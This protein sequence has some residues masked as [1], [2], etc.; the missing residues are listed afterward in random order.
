MMKRK[1]F[2]LKTNGWD[3]GEKKQT[4]SQRFHVLIDLF[5][6]S[7]G[8]EC[9]GSCSL[10]FTDLEVARDGGP[11]CPE[12]SAEADE[13]DD[14]G[15]GDDVDLDEVGSDPEFD[16]G[17]SQPLSPDPV[18]ESQSKSPI[19]GPFSEE[20]CFME[21]DEMMPDSQP[22]FPE[23]PDSQPG[24]PSVA[25]SPSPPKGIEPDDCDKMIVIEDTPDKGSSGETPGSMN[26]VNLEIRKIQEALKHAK[27]M[28]MARSFVVDG[29]NSFATFLFEVHKFPIV[30]T[31]SPWV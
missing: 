4:G 11:P 18:D 13:P 31:S 2:G 1:R 30:P 6:H 7:P 27:K 8:F 26:D 21:S 20:P 22:F 19:P 10:V 15:S 29:S 28:K 25:Y 24:S 14:D 16:S 9:W 12:P 17:D 23:F 5:F 3:S